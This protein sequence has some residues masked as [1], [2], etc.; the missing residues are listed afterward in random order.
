MGLF[1]FAKENVKKEYKSML[2]KLAEF[3]KEN[4]NAKVS[5]VGYT[6]WIGDPNYNV[7]L[8]RR[9]AIQVQGF[10]AKKGVKDSQLIVLWHGPNQPVASN[11][12]ALG[13]A[14]NRR[15]ELMINSSK[16]K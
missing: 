1:D 4:S 7:E 6:D 8:S 13:R 15:V 11:K 5:I 3:L 14:Q 9:R 10:L 2:E 16:R 12:T